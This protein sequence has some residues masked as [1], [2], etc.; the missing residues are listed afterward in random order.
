MRFVRSGDTV[1]VHSIDRLAR[2][3]DDLRCIVQTLTGKGV[4]IG[5]LTVIEADNRT[6]A[7]L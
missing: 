5:F 4:P 7:H 6:G 1:F 2:N 3:L